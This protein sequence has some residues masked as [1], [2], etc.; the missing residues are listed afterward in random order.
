MRPARPL[1]TW[2]SHLVARVAAEHGLA[3]AAV[4]VVVDPAHRPIP[5]AA[6][7]A[8]RPDGRTDVAALLRDLM[9]R[10]SQLPPLARIAFDALAA[11]AAMQRVRPLL[12]PHFG[13]F[14]LT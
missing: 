12:G 7:L 5:R 1:S 13:L 10:P 11:R 3:F 14:D 2:S 4:R 6:L 8:M 9:A